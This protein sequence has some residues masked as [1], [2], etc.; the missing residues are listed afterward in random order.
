MELRRNWKEKTERSNRSGGGGGY[1]PRERGSGQEEPGDSRNRNQRS[2]REEE[3]EKEDR[4]GGTR[5]ETGAEGG[6][7]SK[8]SSDSSSSPRRI[9]N[10]VGNFY[11]KICTLEALGRGMTGR[12]EEDVIMNLGEDSAQRIGVDRKAEIEVLRRKAQ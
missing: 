7:S 1:E 10:Y 5:E 6:S 4:E 2:D 3:K 11:A 8:G 12:K 9:R